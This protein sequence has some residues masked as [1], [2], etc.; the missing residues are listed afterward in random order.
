ME[1]EAPKRC[2]TDIDRL[3]Q[4]TES[5]RTIAEKMKL[6]DIKETYGL[7]EA[8]NSPALNLVVTHATPA[9]FDGP[10]SPISKLANRLLRVESFG[11]DDTGKVCAAHCIDKSQSLQVEDQTFKISFMGGSY[12][13][14]AVDI[15][16]LRKI[17]LLGAA[18]VGKTSI[19]RQLVE[20]KIP[21]THH[22]TVQAIYTRAINR[23]GTEYVL[24][25]LDTEP[26]DELSIFHAM[27][28]MGTY[29]FLV[30][31]AV[32]NRSSF[33]LVKQIYKNIQENTVCVPIV[34]VGNK[35]DL[36][37]REVSQEEADEL[38]NSWFCKYV[39]TTA[40]NY[41]NIRKLIDLAMDEIEGP[42]E[43]KDPG[44]RRCS[45]IQELTH[46]PVAEMAESEGYRCVIQ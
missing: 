19:A 11:F 33:E 39:E 6:K 5:A 23:G 46:V 34:L 16:P 38:A 28:S 1:D 2:H 43:T 24:S 9:S 10:S 41:S 42:L 27:Y 26:Q 8:G 20:R 12:S 17:V 36:P 31:F 18:D 29:C 21:E 3:T 14:K 44:V 35:S 15:V 45:S 7:I 22:H 25:L 4:R 13:K 32:N 37:N 30:V 40:L